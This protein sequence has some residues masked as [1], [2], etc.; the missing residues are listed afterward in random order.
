M[1]IWLRRWAELDAEVDGQDGAAALAGLEARLRVL[2]DERAIREVIADYG[3]FAD[4]GQHD[5]W[6]SNFTADGTIELVGREA[7]GI[8]P[9]VAR[10]TGPEA[11]RDFI[12][13]PRVHMTIE[14]RCMHVTTGN[15]RTRIDGDDAVAETY[16]VVLVKDGDSIVVANGGFTQLQL[17]RVDG[18]WRIQRRLRHQIGTDVALLRA[19]HPRLNGSVS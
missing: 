16:Y 4:S 13:D 19:G 5:E 1:A 11:L 8:Y 9:E 2:E 17:R 14:G 6:V 15:L 18:L 3:F 10:W 12:D 7:T